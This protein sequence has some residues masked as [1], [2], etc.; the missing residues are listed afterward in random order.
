MI[1][2]NVDYEI[3]AKWPGCII[4]GNKIT[5]EQAMQVMIATD[6]TLVSPLYS[7]QTN[8]TRGGIL[9]YTG[10][11]L[12]FDDN[13]SIKDGM[14]GMWAEWRYFLIKQAN[15]M[16]LR[17]LYNSFWSDSWVD[18]EGEIYQYNNLGKYPFIEE[19]LHEFYTIQKVF[20]FLQLTAQ[21]YSD[22]VCYVRSV[23]DITIKTQGENVYVTEGDH[24]TPPPPG[25]PRA[26]EWKHDFGIRSEAEVNVYTACVRE[27][28]LRFKKVHSI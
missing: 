2:N 26:R 15:W 6:H 19:V 4:T 25:R 9:G 21:L 14:M 11:S 13:G 12:I 20:P 10:M 23:H 3:E 5:Q 7:S 18:M 16:E 1:I 24:S 27:L 22:E 8:A 17:Y 28:F